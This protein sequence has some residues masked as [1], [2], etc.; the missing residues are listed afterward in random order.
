MVIEYIKR[1]QKLGYEGD[2]LVYK[3]PLNE[4]APAVETPV[5]QPAPEAPVEEEAVVLPE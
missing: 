2:T 3:V 4:Q 1:G 5:E